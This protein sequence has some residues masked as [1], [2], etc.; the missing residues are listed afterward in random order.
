[1]YIV[2]SVF[3]FLTFETVYTKGGNK[4]YRKAQYKKCEGGLPTKQ[5]FEE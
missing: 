5:N 4:S 3:L 2:D 1:M